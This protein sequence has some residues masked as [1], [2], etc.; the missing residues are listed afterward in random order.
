MAQPM[1]CKRVY[2]RRCDKRTRPVG[3]TFTSSST[4]SANWPPK[5]VMC[6]EEI[7][8]GQGRTSWHAPKDPAANRFGWVW[9]HLQATSDPAWLL[10]KT[11]RG[12][13]KNRA[14]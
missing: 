6:G 4:T 9:R 5:C 11:G 3:V 8:P 12:W 1:K 14:S 13:S 10:C 2:H 7:L